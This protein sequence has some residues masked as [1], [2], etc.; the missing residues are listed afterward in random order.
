MKK[1]NL[2]IIALFCCLSM[3]AFA[4]DGC[5]TPCPAPS[6]CEKPKPEPC[7]KKMYSRPC[8]V[9][10]FLCTEK[11]K[12]CLFDAANLSE[13]QLCA[14]NKIQDKYELEVLSLNERIK[15]EQ[16]RLNSLK[17]SCAS[18]SE[19]RK[20]KKIIEE[21]KNDRKDICKCYEAQFRDMLSSEQ[22][23]AY[24]NAKKQ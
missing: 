18:K 20:Q 10:T 2:L 21:L 14:A 9:E 7:E 13:S 23:S 15:C 16:E 11:A 1:I 19:M 6:P 12:D 22:W 24:K 17:R 8:P 3:N 4:E 5:K